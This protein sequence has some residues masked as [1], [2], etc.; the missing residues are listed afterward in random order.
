M[1]VND[2]NKY[3][4]ITTANKRLRIDFFHKSTDVKIFSNHNQ[5]EIGLM[6]N[7]SSDWKIYELKYEIYDNTIHEGTTCYDYRKQQENY[8]DCN[9][10]TLRVKCS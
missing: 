10:N 9:Y 1:E 8:G 4:H 6:S 5:L 7:T 3:L 2:L